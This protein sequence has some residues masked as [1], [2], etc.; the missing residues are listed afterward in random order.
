VKDAADEDSSALLPVKDNMFSAFNPAKARA[1]LVT[2]PPQLGRACEPTA[3]R[4]EII[5]ISQH[6]FFS[7]GAESVSAN[8]EQIGLRPARES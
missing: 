3:S 1:N 6:L 4:L 7:P 2:R 5:E 8:I